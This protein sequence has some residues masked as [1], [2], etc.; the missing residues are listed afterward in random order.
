MSNTKATLKNS[1]QNNYSRTVQEQLTDEQ[2]K[3]INFFLNIESD[4]KMIEEKK[5]LNF[6]N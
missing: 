6:K 3:D 2:M 5:H 1:S 4:K